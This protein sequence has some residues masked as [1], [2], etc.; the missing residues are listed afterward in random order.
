MTAGFGSKRYDKLIAKCAHTMNK[1]KLSVV[2]AT[3][4]EEENI[5]R[6]LKSVEKIAD[7]IIVV[8][9][10]SSDKTPELARKLGAKV[11]SMPNTTHFHKNK[12]IAVDAASGEWIL[13]L[14]ADEVLSPKL[15]AEVRETV[16][17]PSSAD[18]YGLPRRN[19]FLGRFLSKGGAYPDYVVRLFKKG[20]GSFPKEKLVLNGITTSNVHAQIEIDGK[21]EYLKNDLLHYGDPSFERYLGRFNRYTSLEAENLVALGQKLSFTGGLDFILY[22][23]MYWFFKRY[24]RHRGY[25]DGFQGFVFALASAL[26]YPVIYMKMW[27]I[28]HAKT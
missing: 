25:V 22:K 21:L 2:L 11:I 14:D 5:V 24:L 28:K 4:Q 7:E 1:K 27:E 12:Q 20:K 13:Q 3:F 17:D 18:G 23:P 8:D 26:H 16:N 9:G 19:W 10:E 15:A 6:C